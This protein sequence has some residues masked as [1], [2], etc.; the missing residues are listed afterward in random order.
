MK[1]GGKTALVTGA[2]KGIGRTIAFALASEGADVI[3]ND[4]DLD[5]AKGAVREIASMG[6]EAMAV[7]GDVSQ[8]KDVLAMVEKA[9]QRFR[10]I[11]LLVN[12]AGVPDTIGP[13]VDQ[14]TADWQRVIDIDLRG[15]YLCSKVVGRYMV[16]QRYGKIVNI[17]SMAGVLSLPMRNAYSSAKAGVIAFTKALASEWARYNINVNAVSPGYTVTPMVEDLIAKKKI[18]SGKVARRIPMGRFGKPEEVAKAVL[19]LLSDDS[20]YI[21]GVNL[22]VDGGYGAFGS[23]GDASKPV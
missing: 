16:A 15:S 1:L 8:E 18:N 22:P 9:I 12:N 13:T 3:I 2:G 19:F 11:D 7:K 20:S 14:D 17:A 21:T 5:S 10:K 4:V 6:C 23:Y